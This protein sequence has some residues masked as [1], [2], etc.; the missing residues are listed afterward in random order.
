MVTDVVLLCGKIH[1][2]DNKM[3]LIHGSITILI[4]LGIL[5]W[6]P[7]EFRGFPVNRSVGIIVCIFGLGVILVEVL[8]RK[9]KNKT[10]E[11]Q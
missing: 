3:N 5:I 11:G 8:K 6:G 10:K 2:K 4:G 1:C 7:I 9:S